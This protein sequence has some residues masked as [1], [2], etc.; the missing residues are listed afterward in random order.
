MLKFFWPANSKANQFVP[1][2]LMDFF[3]QHAVQD[4]FQMRTVLKVAQT[5]EHEA[6]LETVPVP[7]EPHH[8]FGHRYYSN[9]LPSHEETFYGTYDFVAFGF[10]LVRS[11]FERSVFPFVITTDTDDPAIGTAFLISGGRILTASH[12]IKAG[13]RASIPGI[14]LKRLRA[15]LAP[16]DDRKDLAALVF[17]EDPAPDRKPFNIGTAVMLD[18]VMTMGYPP[19]PGFHSVLI[20]ETA[21]LAGYLH[22]TTGQLIAQYEAYMDRQDYLL[23]SARVKGGS[24]GGP[25][26]N[27]RGEVVGLIANAPSSDSSEIDALGFGIA[28][29]SPAILQFLSDVQ[30]KENL[31]SIKFAVHGTEVSIQGY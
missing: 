21:R 29:P 23:I 27:K 13:Y 15:I 8:L 26:L 6:L 25:V 11:E 31:R 30:R 1:Y 17:D 16:S 22:S 20:A 14:D 3:E 19:V 4:P 12:C 24:S 18:E 7:G 10:S 9:Y 5:L 2:K 28:V